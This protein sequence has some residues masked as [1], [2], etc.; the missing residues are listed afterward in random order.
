[1]SCRNLVVLLVCL[2]LFV[3]VGGTMAHEESE[4]VVYNAWA[5]PTAGGS[6][7]THGMHHHGGQPSGTPEMQMTAQPGASTTTPSAAYFTI[8]NRGNHPI[9]LTAVTTPVAGRTELHRT[10][11]ENEVARME[12]VEEGVEIADDE[13][14]SFEPG[15]YHVM[16]LD[17]T[18]DLRPGDYIA[19]TLSFDMLD[20]GARSMDVSVGAMIQDL[21][22]ETGGAVVYVESITYDQES[23][24]D[25][26]ATLMVEYHGERHNPLAGMQHMGI[27]LPFTTVPLEGDFDG[28]EV[29]V[30]L[31]PMF[32]MM[33]VPESL[34]LP[35]T[36]VLADGTTFDVALAFPHAHG[37]D[38]HN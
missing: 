11:V 38:G 17:L 6:G 32:E 16:L 29:E 15:G 25:A 10:V 4:I 35:V 19:L 37:E 33:F 20:S 1:M 14:L 7:G 5:R 34:A 13:S 28:V 18:Q 2:T 36:L 3:L 27:E 31:G 23:P 26:R 21:P 24:D 30:G 9:M 22:Y 12:P 8:E